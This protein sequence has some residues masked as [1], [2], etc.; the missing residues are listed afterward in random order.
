MTGALSRRM[1][2][3]LF[4]MSGAAG[5]YGIQEARYPLT[6]RCLFSALLTAGIGL[7]A[8]WSLSHGANAPFAAKLHILERIT[9]PSLDRLKRGI[10]DIF[11]LADAELSSPE[12]AKVSY[13]LDLIRHGI[14]YMAEWSQDAEEWEFVDAKGENR[15][16][17]CPL[18]V[19]LLRGQKVDGWLHFKVDGIGE[20]ELRGC[21]IRL[22]A[23]S[24]RGA[25]YCE[26]PG[27]TWPMPRRDLAMKKKRT[28]DPTAPAFHDLLRT[29]ATTVV[30][31]TSPPARK[32][33]PGSSSAPPAEKTSGAWNGKPARNH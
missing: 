20:T 18:A 25:V 9:R 1:A 24:K 4:A 17:A 10:V 8:W 30:V 28:L 22:W 16:P 14:T 11:F 21:G 2:L 26:Y 3:G 12:D 7:I 33:K 23:R 19:R 15:G 13:S 32:G 5:I 27:D 29:A 31:P 6:D